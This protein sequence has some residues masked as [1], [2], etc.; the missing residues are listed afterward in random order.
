MEFHPPP[1][2][3]AVKGAVPNM[4]SFFTTPAFFWRPVG[5]MK[6]LI[7]CPN[8]NA[9]PEYYLEKR[10]YGSYARQ[11]CGMNFHYTLLTERLMCKHCLKLREEPSQAHAD[12]SND[13]DDEKDGA[14]RA[15]QQYTW[16]AYSPKILMNLAPAIRSMFPAIICGKR[17]VDRS[18]VTLMSD[19]LNAVSMSK[20]RDLYQTLL[21]DAHTS[22]TGSSSSQRGILSFARAAGTYTPPI[23][24]SPLPS[25]RVLR[26]AHLILEMEKMPVYRDLI[27]STTGEI[28]CIDGTRKI[29]KKIYSDGQGTMQ[30]VTSVLNEWGQFLTT[31]VVASESEGGYA[32]MARGL[33]ARFRHANA[34]APKVVYADNNC[35]RDSG[36]SFLENLFGDW[37]KRGTVIRLDIRQ[38]DMML[39]V[40]AVRNGNPELYGRYSDEEMMAFLKPHQIRSYVRRITRGVVV[41]SPWHT[42]VCVWV[43]VMNGV[44]L[45]KHKCRR[46]SNSLEGLHAHLFNAVPSQRCGIMPFQVYLVSFA[47]QW[48]H[49]MASLRVTGGH[50]WQTSCL[51]ARQIQRVN[52]QAEVLLGKEHVLEPNFAAPMSVPEAYEHPDEEELLGVEYAM[53]QSTSFTAR[54][55]YVQKSTEEEEE[56]EGLGMSSDTEEDPIDRVCGKH[57]VLTQA[58][59]AEEEDSPALQDVLMSHGHLH[60]PGIEEVEALALLLL[61]LADNSDHHL[62]PADL[63]QKIAVAASSLHDH[64]KTTTRF[65]KRYES[66]WGYTLFG[67]CLGADSP[68]TRAA[69]K[70]KFGCMRYAQ[71]AQVTEDSLLLYFLLKMLKNR[72]PA[73]QLTSPSK[74]TASLKGQYKRI[75]DRVRDDPI[76]GG[77]AI[78]LPNLNAKSIS[79]FS[80]REEKKANYGATVLPKVTPHLKVL[81]DASFLEAPVLPTSL[82]PPDRPQVQYQHVHHEAGKRRGEKRSL[83]SPRRR[84]PPLGQSLLRPPTSSKSLLRPP[85]DHP[86]SAA[87]IL[88]VLPAQ[89]QAPSVLFCGPSYS[90]SFV[91]PAPTVK[92]FMPNKSSRPCG[93]YHV[94]NCGGQRKRYTPSKDKVAGSTQKIFSY[95]PSTRKSTTSVFDNVVYDSFE[96]FKSVVDVELEK[97]RTV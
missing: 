82:P 97:R 61:E 53:C 37:V 4:L 3:M 9:P 5:V 16:L 73:N 47:V 96:H 56:E 54:D 25:A 64:D 55:Y 72:A 80:A 8:T 43:V 1:P 57:V 76:L 58:E 88:L 14:H 69:Q 29:L 59:Q 94:P 30:Y 27:L 79:T 26:R 71:A 35:C 51:D 10:G 11:V 49:R 23:A 31:V 95:C 93:A 41:R 21:Y 19:R 62:V 60:L 44:R 12:N 32:R 28:L 34:P 17:A 33:V 89:P 63:R 52:Q 75:A 24:P 68:E 50:G 2:P 45:N 46:G 84:P 85:M 36:S 42:A 81:S 83:F 78:P 38:A 15:Q 18:V 86:V 20:R 22:A 91:P 39:L 66:R 70:T 77:L 7:R 67:R 48:N 13:F 74:V 92:A 40:Q 90:Q 87:P 6:A 65:V